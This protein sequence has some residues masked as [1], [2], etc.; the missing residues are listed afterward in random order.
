MYLIDTKERTMPK[1]STTTETEGTAESWNQHDREPTTEES[2]RYPS[3]STDRPRGQLSRRTALRLGAFVGGSLLIGGPTLAGAVAGQPEE[4]EEE[5][6]PVG[7]FTKFKHKV[8]DF[9]EGVLVQFDGDVS[10]G[11][12]NDREYLE[13]E[14]EVEPTEKGVIIQVT[15][16]EFREA[17]ELEQD[18]PE[19]VIFVAFESTTIGARID[20]EGAVTEFSGTPDDVA[21]KGVIVQ[22]GLEGVGTSPGIESLDLSVADD[23]PIIE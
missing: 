13:A 17:R 12:P 16:G 14:A 9:D 22:I 18:P 21:A 1:E 5:E 10:D 7:V 11:E 6:I 4:E 20:S 8:A 19:T 15:A 23:V 3:T 2:M